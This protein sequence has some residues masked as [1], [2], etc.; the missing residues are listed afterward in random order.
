M[1]R[2]IRSPVTRTAP[3]EGRDTSTIQSLD[4]GLRIIQDL[5]EADQPLRLQEVA[6]RYDIDKASAFRFLNT[7]Q[8]FGIARKDQRTKRYTV[9]S[10]L[11]SWLALA[12]SRLPLIDLARPALHELA[13]AT[14]QSAHLGILS[15]DSALLVDFVAADS[16]VQV[17]NRIGVLEPLYCT[18]VGKA[19]LAFLPERD[20]KALLDQIALIRHTPTTITDRP[21]L[22]RQ[23]AQIRADG[24]AVDRAE[25][26]DLLYCVA[27]PVRGSDG[28]PLCS[29]GVS[30]V[31]A[32]FANDPAGIK[33]LKNAVR[34][35]GAAI[36]RLLGEGPEPHE[37]ASKETGRPVAAD[38]RTARANSR[39]ARP[40]AGDRAGAGARPRR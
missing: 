13:A 3:A 15:H 10:R 4:R 12:R 22:E 17:K 28:M 11:L 18:A 1:S 40:F 2:P 7:L 14:G 32:F 20:R 23:L 5:V 39:T 19:I 27:V 16:V 6:E 30:V 29:V 34:R 24:V 8:A 37:V 35:A 25:F 33:L 36:E 31:A 38:S 21:A 26:S 9:G